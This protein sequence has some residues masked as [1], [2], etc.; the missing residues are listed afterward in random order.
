MASDMGKA[1]FLARAAAAL[2][3]GLKLIQVREKDWPEAEQHAF[4]LSVC[5]LARPH[6]ARVLLNGSAERARAWGCDGV[7]WTSTSLA[8][9]TARPDGLSCSASCHTRV[10][11]ARAGALGLDFAVLGPVLP[12]PTHEDAAVLGWEG[13]AAAT[14][15]ATLPVFAL[16]GLVQGDLET[17]IAHGAH[18]VAMRR[19]AWPPATAA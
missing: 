2:D 1:G 7:H 14:E 3:G 11:V 17:A 13:F 15:G 6:G 18:G 4:C 10:D 19:G 5:E 8:A 9:A 16:G 12:T